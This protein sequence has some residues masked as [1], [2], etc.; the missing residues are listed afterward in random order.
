[1]LRPPPISARDRAVEADAAR[2]LEEDDVA[3][4][5]QRARAGRPP[6]PAIVDML[7]R[8]RGQARRD[9]ALADLAAARPDADEPVGAPRGVPAR[10]AMPALLVGAELEHVAQHR[11]PA[12]RGQRRERL[13]AARIEAGFAL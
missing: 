2:G 1:M 11:D 7:D 8:A 3:L 4:G 6:P 13:Q 9:G 12:P 5:E 10:L